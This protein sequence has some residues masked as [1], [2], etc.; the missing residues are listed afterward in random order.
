[1]IAFPKLDGG[2]T[3]TNRDHND[4]TVGV[5]LSCV[6]VSR[7]DLGLR[8]INSS[9]VVRRWTLVETTRIKAALNR[10][11]ARRVR[12]SPL[13]EIIQRNIWREGVPYI[14]L[15]RGERRRSEED[16]RERDGNSMQVPQGTMR[17][18][19]VLI[20]LQV[21]ILR[22][23]HGAITADRNPRSKRNSLSVAKSPRVYARE[24]ART[25]APRSFIFV[26]E[27]AVRMRVGDDMLVGESGIEELGQI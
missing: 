18:Q 10:G 26:L 22:Y 13:S 5:P 1:V 19:T 17:S 27:G 14:T 11:G 15:R 3:H 25:F 12:I 6:L 9:H 16:S 24:G 21:P 2:I 20:G 4:L 7:V 23:F 8:D